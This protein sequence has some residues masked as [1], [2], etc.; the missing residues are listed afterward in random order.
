MTKTFTVLASFGLAAASLFGQYSP[1]IRVKVPFSF[2][3]G[4]RTLPAGE[5]LVETRQLPNSALVRSSDSGRAMVILLTNPSQARGS[6]PETCL[7]FHRYGDRYFLHQIWTAG[8]DVGQ[9]LPQSRAET[10]EAAVRHEAPATVAL[11][12]KR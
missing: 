6:A 3:A 5:Y 12:A 7:M 11:A 2:T 10:E 8:N 4:G 1:Q 9:E